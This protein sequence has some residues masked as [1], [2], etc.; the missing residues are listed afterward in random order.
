MAGGR[1]LAKQVRARLD[2]EP[3]TD[4]APKSET[5]VSYLDELQFRKPVRR[6][7]AEFAAVFALIMVIVAGSGAYHGK[8][9]STVFTWIAAAMVL[10]LLGY[11]TP[12][13]LHPLWKGWMK[14]AH[15]LGLVMTTLILAVAWTIALIPTAMG[16]KIFGI[17]VMDTTYGAKVS[18]Y[19]ETRDPKENDFQLLKRQF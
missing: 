5:K 18:T 1:G 16:L 11:K 4:M 2:D 19:W 7:V 17:K 6:H 8:P 10:L 9:L 15:V 3:Q 13:V 14:F 12:G